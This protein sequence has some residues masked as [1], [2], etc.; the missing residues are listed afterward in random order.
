MN[1]ARSGA[2]PRTLIAAIPRELWQAAGAVGDIA[3]VRKRLAAY[4]DAGADQIGIVPVTAGDPAGARLLAAPK[5]PPER[6]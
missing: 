3:C 6:P 4:A 2:H 1:T 5:P